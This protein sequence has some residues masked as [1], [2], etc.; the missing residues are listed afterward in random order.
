MA[1]CYSIL[2]EHNPARLKRPR[3]PPL[4]RMTIKHDQTEPDEQ[5]SHDALIQPFAF[6]Y[7]SGVTR[8]KWKWNQQQALKLFTVFVDNKK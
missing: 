6:C 1:T 7:E 3:S 2:F 5:Q 4:I 8:K